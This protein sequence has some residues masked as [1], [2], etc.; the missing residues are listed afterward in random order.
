MLAGSQGVKPFRGRAQARVAVHHFT[1]ELEGPGLE[2]WRGSQ[3]PWVGVDFFYSMAGAWTSVKRQVLEKTSKNV[4]G[5]G[6]ALA[7]YELV[8][9]K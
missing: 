9:N 1:V 2:T 3:C 6:I 5:M 4:F 8:H 7:M